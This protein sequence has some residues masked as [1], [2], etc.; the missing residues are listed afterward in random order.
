[1]TSRPPESGKPRLL[2]L[3][4]T[5]PR[6]KGDP[7]PGFVHEL[8]SR[9]AAEFDVQVVCPAAPGARSREIM[10]GVRIHRFRYAPEKLQ[11]LIN[12]GGLTSNLRKSPWKYFLVPG[13]L[14]GMIW[15]STRMLRSFKPSVIHSHWIIPQGFVAILARRLSGRSPPLVVTSHGADAYAW[16]S[17][18]STWFKRVVVREAAVVTVV[19]RAIQR[20]IA[21]ICG[22]PS[23]TTVAPMG[24]DLEERFAPD[25]GVR[26]SPAEILF[27]GRLVEKKGLRHLIDA[28]PMILSKMP[29]AKLVIAG[30]GP[31]EGERKLQAKALGVAHAIEFLGAIQQERLPGLYRRASVFVAPFVQAAGGD[32]DGL[33]LVSVE[34][35]G[36]GCPVVV[37]RL[38]AVEDIFDDDEA[39]FVEPGNP[40]DMAKAILS[41]LQN[42][43]ASPRP[44]RDALVRRFGW[45][46]VASTYA[47]ILQATHSKT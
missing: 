44:R 24:V 41:V 45:E 46:S 10:D 34:A 43:L 22:A 37:S 36:C 42:P 17:H 35:A 2:V 31:E 40:S 21:D 38:P 8:S 6:W 12:N 32:Q 47:E 16:K 15:A 27:V 28:M 39:I 29:H 33:G 11:T 18:L 23:A 4:S 13:F 19:S 14:F 26:R 9:L 7:E 20:E 25:S 30:F 3:A 1:M 5:Y